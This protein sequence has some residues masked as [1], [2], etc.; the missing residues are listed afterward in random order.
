MSILITCN[1]KEG[2]CDQLFNC[3]LIAIKEDESNTGDERQESSNITGPLSD[4]FE[5]NGTLPSNGGLS[6]YSI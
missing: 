4:D 2:Y 3:K 5:N 1:C 6:S